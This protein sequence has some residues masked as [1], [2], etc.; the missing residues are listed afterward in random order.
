[1]K[2]KEIQKL[3]RALGYACK[4][5]INAI[6]EAPLPAVDRSHILA[7]V[8]AYAQIRLEQVVGEDPE[9]LPAPDA[10]VPDEDMSFLD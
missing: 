2:T 9:A 8:T 7:D 5:A 4:E 1:M 6:V 3:E 10:E